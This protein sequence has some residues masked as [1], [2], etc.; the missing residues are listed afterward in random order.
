MSRCYDD[1]DFSSCELAV[2]AFERVNRRGGPLMRRGGRSGGNGEGA[3]G[4]AEVLP[5]YGLRDFS[6]VNYYATPNPGGEPGNATSFG[7]SMAMVPT[8]LSSANQFLIHRANNGVTAGWF[9]TINANALSFFAVN[10]GGAYIKSTSYTITA[11]DIG[12]VLHFVARFD[13]SNLRLTVNRQELAP[14]AL[15]TY[16]AHTGATQLGVLFA[17]FPALASTFLWWFTFSGAP[18]VAQVAA[19]ADA[20]RAL[21]GVMP[22]SFDGATVTHGWPVR[23][24]LGT[25]VVSGQVAPASLADSVTAA[26]ADAMVRV[27]SP[28]VIAIDPNTPRLWGYET[29]PLLYGANALTTGDHFEA[30]NGF[31]GDPAG[32]W[33]CALIMINSQA[34]GIG[35]ANRNIFARRAAANAGWNLQTGALNSTISFSLGGTGGAGTVN[36]P[37]QIVAA[38]DVGKLLLVHGVWD[39]PSLTARL[40]CKRLQL[41]T[42]SVFTGG[43]F[44]AETGVTQIGRRQNGLAADNITIFGVAAGLGIPT[45][46]GV[47]AHTDAVMASEELASGIPSLTTSLLVNLKADIVANGSAMP[48]SLLDRSGNA[49]SFAR[50]GNPAV[51]SQY[52]RAWGW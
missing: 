30:A 9:V 8:T 37:S 45:L 3:P 27:G 31:A 29:A 15:A 4:G 47:Q 46:A 13:G 6:S 24:A 35:S 38:G 33:V 7:L 40:Y 48:A 18:S 12:R 10:S 39:A 22:T 14:V 43:T 16:L 44:V 34:S 32:F 36:S 2:R 19:H 17:T 52:A 42:G 25:T 49:Q 23:N 1:L 11:S 21:G 51:A 41:S 28:T 20:V 26:T 5:L 50:V